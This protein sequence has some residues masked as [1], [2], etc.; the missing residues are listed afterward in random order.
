MF[1]IKIH[2]IGRKYRGEDNVWKIN[3]DDKLPSLREK[4]VVAQSVFW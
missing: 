3:R 4:T 1:G 2:H